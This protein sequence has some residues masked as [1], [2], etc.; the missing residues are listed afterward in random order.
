[1]SNPIIKGFYADPDIAC[2]GGRY[3]IYPTTDGGKEWDSTYFK[4]FSS[5]DLKNWTDEGIILDFKDVPWTGG[6]YAWAPAVCERNGKYYFYYTGNGNIGVAVS[7]TP[8]GRFRDI[9]RPLI[10]QGTYEGVSIDHDVFIDDDGSAYLYWGNGHM[11]AARLGEDMIS[12]AGEPVDITPPNFREGTCVFKR[13]GIYYFTW[14][15]DDTRSP[16]YHVRYGKGTSPIEKPEGNTV[17]LHRR[18]A[19][20][21]RIRGTGHHAILNVPDTD[22]WYICYHRF[23]AEKHGDITGY[24]TEAGNHRELCLDRLYFNDHGD[25]LPVKATY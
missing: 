11:Y 23:N 7:D 4:A 10:K 24:S 5:P 20:D 9:G 14:C 2:F 17:L 21:S 1:M 6:K 25:I 15:E 22:E 19:E 12:L 16:D 3:Y 13:R 8:T 18:N